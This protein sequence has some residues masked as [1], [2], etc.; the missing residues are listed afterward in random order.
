[1]SSILTIG[2]SLYG[3]LTETPIHLASTAAE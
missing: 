3:W 2:S 1:V